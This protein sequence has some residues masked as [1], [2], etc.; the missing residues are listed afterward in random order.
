MQHRAVPPAQ[1]RRL[2]HVVA[3]VAPRLAQLGQQVVHNTLNLKA[4]F[5]T[6]FS[7]H[8]FKV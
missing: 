1:P 6:S 8:S 3:Q 5:E 2:H 4:N 7:L